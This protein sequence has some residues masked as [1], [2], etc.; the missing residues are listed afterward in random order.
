MNDRLQLYLVINKKDAGW[1]A[2]DYNCIPITEEEAKK[3]KEEGK[4]VIEMWN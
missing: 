4:E 2:D 1:N 3:A